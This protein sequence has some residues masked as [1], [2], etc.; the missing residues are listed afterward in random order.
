QTV[1]VWSLRTEP[2]DEALAIAPFVRSIARPPRTRWK[3]VAAVVAFA[4]VAALIA[5]PLVARRA[6]G[7]SEIEPNS[8]GVLDPQSGEVTA[9]VGLKESPGSVAAS[10]E[11]VWVT[12][13]DVGT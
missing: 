8:V 6:G 7:S 11:A 12:N 2:R 10:T 1:H 13:P 9:T 3:A 4:V 5:I